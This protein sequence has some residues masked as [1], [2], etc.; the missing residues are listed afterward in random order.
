MYQHRTAS[1]EKDQQSKHRTFVEA[2]A[3]Q[4]SVRAQ[5]HARFV[6]AQEEREAANRLT[7]ADEQSRPNGWYFHDATNEDA[8][9]H[10]AMHEFH[11]EMLSVLDDV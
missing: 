10:C 9:E 1:G 8:D 5:E 7:A 3:E 2:L 6:A 11:S 4:F